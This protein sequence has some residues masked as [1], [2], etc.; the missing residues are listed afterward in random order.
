MVFTV[1]QFT[2]PAEIVNLELAV[3]HVRKWQRMWSSLPSSAPAKV[4]KAY[5]SRL[6]LAKSLVNIHFFIV[7]A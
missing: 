2:M 7:G 3:A 1:T 6:A 5:L 4:R